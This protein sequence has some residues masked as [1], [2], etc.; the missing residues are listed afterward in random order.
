MEVPRV[1]FI[2]I[3][4]S[5]TVPVPG[6]RYLYPGTR[7]KPYEPSSLLGPRATAALCLCSCLPDEDQENSHPGGRTP[8][9]QYLLCFSV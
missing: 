7:T 1:L 8:G 9:C 6:T 2:I 3:H 5:L 4:F